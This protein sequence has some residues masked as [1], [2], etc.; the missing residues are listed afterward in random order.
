MFSAPHRSRYIHWCADSA[1]SPSAAAQT[2]T[3][4]KDVSHQKQQSTG[5]TPVPLLLLSPAETD[6]GIFSH[7][8]SKPSFS[9]GKEGEFIPSNFISDTAPN[10]QTDDGEDGDDAKGE[11]CSRRRLLTPE[12]DIQ[13]KEELSFLRSSD[14]ETVHLPR[15][16]P[17]L[18]RRP[19]SWHGGR[20]QMTD[21]SS[22]KSPALSTA[23]LSPYQHEHPTATSMEDLASKQTSCRME[24]K[25]CCSSVSSTLKHFL[26]SGLHQAY[27]R[28]Q[29]LA[30]DDRRWSLT[31]C[32]A[33]HAPASTDLS[34]KRCTSVL[35]FSADI[36][37]SA[38]EL[39]KENSHFIV[40]DMVLEV[41]ESVK[42]TLRFDQRV[43]MAD[44]RDAHSK[45]CKETQTC[46]AQDSFYP[47]HEDTKTLLRD[48]RSYYTPQ[49]TQG[50]DK[51]EE[52]DTEA[53]HQTKALS[54][55]S[56]DSGFED[57]GIDTSVM[58]RDLQMNAE[59]LAEQLVLKFRRSWL[60]SHELCRGRQSLRSSLQ[61]LPGM[62]G[63][64]VS[65]GSLTEEIRLRTRM[66]G[67][68]NWAPPRFQIIF[69]IQP[70]HRRSEVVAQQH[71]LCAGCGT[72]V[73]PRYI[74]KLRYCE[75]IGRYFCDC[76]H[77]GSEAVIPARVLSNWDFGRYSVSDFSR[78][79]LDSVW[80]QPLFDLTCV[81]KTLYSRVKELGKFRELREQLLGI[82]K[83][84]KACRLSGSVASELEQLPAH[85]LEQPHLFS[86][87]D[88]A[89]VK[90]GQLVPQA[91]AA[92]QSAISHIENCELCLARGFICEF[93]R[94]NDVIFPF[95]T[96]ICKRCTVCKA[97][98]HKDCFT[99]KL[100][101]K[102]A[103]IQSRKKGCDTAVESET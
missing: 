7:R 66:R 96:D 102:C 56:T 69:T 2:T 79:L 43:S 30:E 44:T 64:A 86:M 24:E 68:L 100:C 11:K 27:S 12:R 73:E 46:P 80:H 22:L 26:S 29:E 81:G 41:L 17:V 34:R 57:C 70:T 19:C 77:S 55:H 49:H 74:K 72:E 76:C 103:R 92:L 101:P 85:L 20:N 91:R 16:S 18:S 75:Y 94:E 31:G 25:Q 32:D 89:K 60:P 51:E 82:K 78:Q 13:R 33:T 95:Q 98:F 10:S 45:I 58:Q 4:T 6:G 88:F 14:N 8:P 90:R 28:Q 99:V 84:L 35:D 61:G 21:H 97:C 5:P 93:C 39:E 50:I 87:D 62:G 36:F 59:Q 40:V 38:C 23:S 42:W 1:E 9:N 67:S 53:Q 37:E 54:V 3:G 52:V 48:S 83:L 63:V 65:S 47:I 15:S 71:F